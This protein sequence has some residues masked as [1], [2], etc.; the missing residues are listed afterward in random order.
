MNSEYL[1][2]QLNRII[3]ALEC[4]NPTRAQI[5]AVHAV[6]E[7]VRF[8]AQNE[9]AAMRDGFSDASSTNYELT[10]G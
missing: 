7:A 8:D 9:A 1:Q 4:R 6:L 5:E 3:F 10:V 2:N